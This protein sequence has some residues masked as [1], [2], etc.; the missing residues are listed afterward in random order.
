MR[1]L[2][3]ADWHLGRSFHGESLLDAQAAS[4]DFIVAAARDSAVDAVLV[5]GDLY[6]RALPP[7]DA[8]R[9][10]GEA[11]TRL[12]EVCPV[13]VISGNHD[14]A[15]R[16]GF[17]SALL[18]RSGL[19]L[20]TEPRACG[21]PLVIGGTC[22]Y[23]IPYLEPDVVR[24]EL[25]CEERGH[26]AVIAAAMARVRADLGSRPAGTRS[27]VLAHAFVAGADGCDSERDLAV[28]G[29]ASVPAGAFAGADYVALGHL[30]GAQ[31]VG[32][33]G[34]Y[35]GSPLAFSFSEARHAKSVAVV[36]LSGLFPQLDLLRCP[37]PR[38]LA[39]LRGTLDELLADPA[40]TRH[41][42]AWVQATVTDPVRPEDAMER[43]R[44]R[45]P[46]A[47]VLAFDPQGSGTPAGASYA[48]RLR[49]LDDA[50]LLSRFVEDVR[51]AAADDDERA[52]LQDA[53]T[54][55]RVSEISA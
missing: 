50:E 32:E 12:S 54:A 24:G 22:V 19:H 1:F 45:F 30:H 6:D 9:L 49:G 52:V 48:D 47:V 53:L 29:A 51:G 55:R 5:S 16:L 8:V 25:E 31:R 4:V 14:S 27:V 20:R 33:N 38:P 15:A 2:H 28:G 34:R 11:L 41:E 39:A 36:D 21:Q 40:H 7:V 18:D 17:G 13:V 43:V 42:A 3:T 46:H 23:G 44:R 26:A 35:A 37:V 10:A